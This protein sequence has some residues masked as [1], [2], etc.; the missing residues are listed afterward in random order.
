M[1]FL[2]ASLHAALH[3]PGV[4]QFSPM[5][6]WAQVA[7][8]TAE[9]RA[10]LSPDSFVMGLGRKYFVPSQLAFHLRAPRD[11]Y[12]RTPLGE[13]D[14]QFDFWTDARALQGR[15]AVVVVEKGY[16]RQAETD[17]GRAFRS[18]ERAGTLV[19]PLRGG[20]PPEFLFFL[21]RGYI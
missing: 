17:L 21:A 7:R 5:H 8:R 9:L 10:G 11:V 14:L 6:G 13:H 19:V 1:L 18:V 12:G 20:K 16:E 2:V 4:P 15:D 3:L